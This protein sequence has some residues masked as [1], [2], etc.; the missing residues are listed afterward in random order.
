M[1][2]GLVP[3]E[4]DRSTRKEEKNSD[5]DVATKQINAPNAMIH[6]SLEE[7]LKDHN[8]NFTHSRYRFTHSQCYPLERGKGS[9][10]KVSLYRVSKRNAA[11]KREGNETPAKEGKLQPAGQL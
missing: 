6:K 10:S 5:G 7:F 2:P 8:V 4:K 1:L 9:L 3:K 11:R